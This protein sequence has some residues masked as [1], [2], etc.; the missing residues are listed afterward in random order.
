MTTPCPYPD[1]CQERRACQRACDMPDTTPDV[2]F[3]TSASEAE[4][5]LARLLAM[6]YTEEDLEAS[7]PYNQWMKE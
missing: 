1:V 5:A 2:G 3:A 6:G 7:N 4:T